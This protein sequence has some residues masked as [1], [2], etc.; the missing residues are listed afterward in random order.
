MQ[1]FSLFEAIN[2]KSGAIQTKPTQEISFTELIDY[3]K[4][5]ENKALSLAILNETNKDK[6]TILKNKRAYYT[7]SGTFKTRRNDA[8]KHHN[9]IISIDIDNLQSKAE[10]LKI[11]E[12]LK[13]HKSILFACLS[14]RGKGVKA[15]MLVDRTYTAQ[16]QYN[17]L[18]NVFKP[19]L[20]DFLK[21][22][23]SHIDSAQFV[24]SQPCT[25]VGMLSFMLMKPQ[26]IYS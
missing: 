24:L 17:Q 13:Q 1:S 10:A 6:Q 2:G 20:A 15:L 16:D 23:Y 19:Y 8:I 11:K 9:N 4:S 22:D 3:Y 21:I 18:K 7:P 25:L 12:K 14:V 26:L 5:D